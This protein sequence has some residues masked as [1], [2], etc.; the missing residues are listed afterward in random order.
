MHRCSCGFR[1]APVVHPAT[2]QGALSYAGLWFAPLALLSL[3]SLSLWPRGS[4]S[5]PSASGTTA[6][7]PGR[8]LTFVGVL[9]AI[10]VAL[11]VS[12]CPTAALPGGS[13]SRQSPCPPGGSAANDR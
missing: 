5:W 3:C 7:A 11:G 2:S 12:C 10:T 6:P 9:A 4:F 1:V 13:R 8:Y